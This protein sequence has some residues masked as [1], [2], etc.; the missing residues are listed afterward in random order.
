MNESTELK[1]GDTATYNIGGLKVTMVPCTLGK[2][3]KAIDVFKDGDKDSF[4]MIQEH[5]FQILSNGQNDFATREWI[6]E[7]LTMPLAVQIMTH[8]RI[9]NGLEQNGFFQKAGAMT[10]KPLEVRDLSEAE[11]RSV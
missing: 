8:M 5:I 4:E 3:K 10:L 2:M 7:N 6:N 9:I 11:T 1:S